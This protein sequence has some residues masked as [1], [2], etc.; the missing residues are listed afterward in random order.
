MVGDGI[1]SGAAGGKNSTSVRE[2]LS[3]ISN[4]QLLLTIRRSKLLCSLAPETRKPIKLR[5]LRDNDSGHRLHNQPH[6]PSSAEAQLLAPD[7]A[8]HPTSDF[9]L[10]YPLVLSSPIFPNSVLIISSSPGQASERA[11]EQI[12]PGCFVRPCAPEAYPPCN[13][14]QTGEM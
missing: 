9:Y 6:V 11:G 10:L 3:T 1:I 8:G 4:S 2:L 14:K 7:N 13:Q 5:S 12:G